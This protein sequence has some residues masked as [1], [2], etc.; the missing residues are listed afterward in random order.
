MLQPAGRSLNAL[1]QHADPAAGNSHNLVAQQVDVHALHPICHHAFESKPREVPGAGGDAAE[2]VFGHTFHRKSGD[3]LRVVPEV[4]GDAHVFDRRIVRSGQDFEKVKMFGV[5]GHRVSG[6]LE[7]SQLHLGLQGARRE[8]APVAGVLEVAALPEVVV[9]V[10]EGHEG[11][12]ELGEGPRHGDVVGGRAGGDAGDLRVHGRVGEDQAPAA[13]QDLLVGLVERRV[14]GHLACQHADVLDAVVRGAAARA[15]GVRGLGEFQLQHQVELRRQEL[16][17]LK[18]ADERGRHEDV[19]VV[20]RGH[21]RRGESGQ[22][23][24]AGDTLVLIPFRGFQK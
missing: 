22:F 7:R 14:Q 12:Q 9:D 1:V 13:E 18:H 19:L 6:V 24:E 20:L 3:E 16:P 11:P 17:G 21:G 2:G 15:Q 4:V 10:P 8:L 23:P 5:A